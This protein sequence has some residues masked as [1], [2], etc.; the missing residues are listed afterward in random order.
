MTFDGK[1]FSGYIRDGSSLSSLA[2]SPA[3]SSD[4]A[5]ANIFLLL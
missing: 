3:T 2:A 4:S 5:F 1:L